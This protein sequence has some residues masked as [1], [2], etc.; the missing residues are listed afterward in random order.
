VDAI[1][2]AANE[3]HARLAYDERTVYFGRDGQIWSATRASWTEP[4]GEPEPVPG[5]NTGDT[6][7]APSLTADGLFL[8]AVRYGATH[9]IVRAQ[10]ATT[11]DPFSAMEPVTALN[12]EGFN[13]EPY[14]LPDHSAIYQRRSA[15]GGAAWDILRTA[16][17]GAS[18]GSNFPV[19]ALDVNMPGTDSAPVV[20]PDE[21]TIYFFTW[22]VD[23]ANNI[24]VAR[25][26]TT[27]D[28]FG[29]AEPLGEPV[30]TDVLESPDWISADGCV[31]YFTRGST[32][33]GSD[34][35]VATRGL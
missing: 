15:D 10:R 26:S 27:A 30:D 35:Y 20:T 21:L 25:R 23:G 2:T 19:N 8:Y 31:L 6:L 12:V 34:I 28:P 14:V 22:R 17:S 29:A 7:D 1:D 13:G 32:E 18:F 4:F 3:A 5:V 11:A 24:Y 33:F 9:E 16:R